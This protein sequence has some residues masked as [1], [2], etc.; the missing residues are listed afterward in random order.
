MEMVI[1]MR[2]KIFMATCA[3]FLK[4][5]NDGN[6]PSPPA[7]NLY[8]LTKGKPQRKE[9]LD[10]FKWVLTDGQNFVSVAGYVP[11]TKKCFSQTSLKKLGK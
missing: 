4:A 6:Y 5:V 8:F 2:M 7:R 3:F 11:L 10:F 1:L 9:V